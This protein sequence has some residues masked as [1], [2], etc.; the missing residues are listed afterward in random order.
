MKNPPVVAASLL[1]A[2]FARF[3]AEARR[4]LSAGADWLHLDVMD[5]QF[6]PNL[7]FGP[8]LCAALRRL[9]PRAFLDVHLMTERPENLLDSFAAAGASAL[10]FHPETVRHPHR[11]ARAVRE[12][13]MRAGAALNPATPAALIEDLIPETDMILVMTVNPGFGGQSFIAETAGKIARV[14]ALLDGEKTRSGRARRA[15]L[16]VD[17]GINPQTAAVC[18]AA[19]ADSYVVG[20]AMFGAKNMRAAV[21]QIRKAAAPPPKPKPQPARKARRKAAASAL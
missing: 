9:A 4:A 18:A 15:R 10:T 16:Q 11:L 7:T 17:G 8:P 3:G 12:R 5:N 20:S 21:S 2:D 13:G 6:V 1:A 19:G 14:A